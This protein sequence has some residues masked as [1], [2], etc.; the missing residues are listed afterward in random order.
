MLAL[1]D[2]QPQKNEVYLDNNA[3]TPVLPQAIEASTHTMQLCYGNPSSSH[4]TGIKAKYILETTR[5]LTRQVIGA[6]TGQVMFTSG[7]TEGIQTAI[8]SSLIAAKHQQ[9]SIENPVLLY[10]ATEHKA[11]PESLKHWN[12]MLDIGAQVLAIPVDERGIL[13]M[14]FI[15]EHVP[16]ALM[17][18]TMIANNETGVYQDLALLEQ[19]IRQHNSDVYWMVDCVQALG[20]IQ[21]SISDTS[22][23]YAPFSGHKLY[24]P[25]GIGILYVRESAPFTPFI[26]GGGQESGLRSGTENLPG[27]AALQAVLALLN[28]EQ[29]DTFKS[30]EQLEKYREQLVQTLTKAF[31]AIVFNHDFTCSLPT[32]IN[33]SVKGLSSKDIMDLFDAAHIRVSAG[34]ACSSKV[35]GSFVLDAMGKPKWQSNSAIR[36]SFGPATSQQEI[37]DACHAIEQAVK[38][39]K[40]SCLILSDTADNSAIGVDGLQQWLYDNGCTWCYVDKATKQ[41]FVIDLA[42]ELVAKF[43]TLVECQGYEVVAVLTTHI[44]Q[45]NEAHQ[46]MIQTLWQN[47]SSSYDVLGWPQN[48]R[49]VSLE[50]ELAVEAITIGNKVIARLPLPGHTENSVAY[51]LGRADNQQLKAVDIEFVFVGDLIQING[52]GRCD[53]QD[54][55]AS[56]LYRSLQLLN[57]VITEQTL[58]CPAH[59]YL[60]L[61]NTTLALEMQSQPMLKQIIDGEISEQAFIE[62]KNKADEQ[63][64]PADYHQYCGPVGSFNN[65]IETVH[66]NQLVKFISDSPNTVVVDVREPHEYDAYPDSTIGGKT[67]VNIPLSQITQ[68]VQRN[69]SGQADNRYVC[70]CRSGKRSEAAA[71]T[72]QRNNF[73]HIYHVPGGFALLNK[74]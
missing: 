47:D 65:I 23:D 74:S 24:A 17:I 52:L 35:T 14:T 6:K 58:L 71:K 37:D 2:I 51:L 69:K 68:F 44:H 31:P 21:L 42:P 43:E 41:C 16:N 63:L 9:K 49:L 7:A 53:V 36:M 26:A 5:D 60:Q 48:T 18:C 19:T 45:A 30:H 34:S 10:G 29:D 56:S 67:M 20:K 33:F 28:D 40:S 13:D 59:D 32:T 8:I 46:N 11:V 22:I 4:I 70:I 61:F 64:P 38:A 12:K 27:I 25:K 15:A 62:Y 3:T 50:N 66:P 57:Q 55:D 39:L 72:L 1:R 54:G 73:T